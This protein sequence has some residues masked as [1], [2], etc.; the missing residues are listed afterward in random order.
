MFL[1]HHFYVSQWRR[2]RLKDKGSNLIS[3]SSFFETMSIIPAPRIEP[4]TSDWLQSSAIALLDDRKND[5][6]RDQPCLELT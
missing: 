6:F 1:E 4:A 5:F 2:D 3:F